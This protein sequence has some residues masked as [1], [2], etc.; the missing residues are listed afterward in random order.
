M[1]KKKLIAIAY[2]AGYEA[3]LSGESRKANLPVDDTV[4][5]EDLSDLIA[6]WYRGFDQAISD[7]SP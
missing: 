1:C 3:A 5:D 7:M 4:P 2:A 6:A